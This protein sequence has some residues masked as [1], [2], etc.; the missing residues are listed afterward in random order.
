MKILLMLPYDKS[1]DW[2]VPDLGLGYIASCLKGEGHKVELCVRPQ[3][4][5]NP[6]EF[7]EFLRK[8]DFDL[9]GIKVIF[10][11]IC[12]VNETIG[13]IDSLGLR[14]AIILGGPQV[15]ADPSAIFKL[16]PG[17][18]YAFRGEAELGIVRFIR[19]FSDGQLSDANLA[20][21]PNLVWRKGAETIINQEER[22]ENL[23]QI[24]FPAWESME[25]ARFPCIPFSNI[26]RR[27]PIAP[28]LMTRGCPSRCSFCGANLINGRRIR[29][30]SAENIMQELRLLT[31]Q[32]GVK[33]IQFFDSNCAHREGPLREICKRI[34]S[35]KIDITWS[36]PN[37]IRIDSIDE[38]LAA[39]MKTSGCFQVSVGIES[40]SE[41]IL[42]QIK[43]GISIDMVKERVKVLRDAGIEVTGFFVIGFPGETI[44]EIE[45]TISFA[46]ELPLTAV[47]F[48][49]LTPLPGTDIYKEVC[50]GQEIE[51]LRRL[52]FMGYRNSLSEASPEALARLQKKA[53]VRFYLRPSIIRYFLKNMNSISKI[54]LLVRR[55]AFVLTR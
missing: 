20:Q 22:I 31:S 35:E 25:P 4:F 41:R 12:A 36:A 29:K 16:I 55:T 24:P 10:S 15:S 30:R 5:K 38:E 32:F 50:A 39:L 18:D 40:G 49:I 28:V 8:G 51:E 26:S 14:A 13:I 1:Y 53:Y 52:S 54:K 46:A 2:A 11:A 37:G 17:A 27:Y 21:V 33:E 48:S 19:Y 43:K 23:D 9:I 45:Q 3:T 34:I 7:A 47:S 42:K 6:S 44:R